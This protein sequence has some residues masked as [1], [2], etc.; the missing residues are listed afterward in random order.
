MVVRFSEFESY[1]VLKQDP[2][3]PGASHFRIA[4]EGGTVRSG[5]SLV[6]R[7]YTEPLLTDGDEAVL[8]LQKGAGCSC[9]W[10]HSG[11]AGQFRF[12]RSSNFSVLRLSGPARRMRDLPAPASGQLATQDF[13]TILSALGDRIRKGGG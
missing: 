13:L 4:Q 12:D 11:G 8:F 9:Y 3:A 1:N 2:K 5:S 10:I 7:A 6:S